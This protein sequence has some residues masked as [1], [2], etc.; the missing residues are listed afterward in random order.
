M[1]K[2][3][4]LAYEVVHDGDGDYQVAGAYYDYVGIFQTID[5]RY[6]VYASDDYTEDYPDWDT[7]WETL[8]NWVNYEGGDF[9]D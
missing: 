4:I 1:P 9:E 6:M 5:G 3:E 8:Q 7:A 2:E